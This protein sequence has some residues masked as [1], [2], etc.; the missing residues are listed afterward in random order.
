MP[1]HGASLLIVTTDTAARESATKR[2]PP[3]RPP[4]PT[5][6]RQTTA[7]E[8][9]E[10]APA[11]AAC[12]AKDRGADPSYSRTRAVAELRRARFRQGIRIRPCPVFV[13]SNPF[14]SRH[15]SRSNSLFFQFCPQHAHSAKHSQLSRHGSNSQ[16]LRDFLLRLVLHQ[17]QLDY[18][19]HASRQFRKR[20][21]DFLARFLT[22]HCIRVFLSCEL[23]WPIQ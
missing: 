1:V 13:C 20:D 11:V 16:R 18:H 7:H 21:R 2:K 3:P 8:P 15:R 17:A 14:S 5:K 10:P 12:P 23:F 19:T 6:P 4:R 22:H 9:G